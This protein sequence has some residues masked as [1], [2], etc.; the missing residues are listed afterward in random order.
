MIFELNAPVHYLEFHILSDYL[1][2]EYRTILM[3]YS[4]TYIGF[5]FVQNYY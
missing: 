1:R 4:H 5:L 2:F 3:I